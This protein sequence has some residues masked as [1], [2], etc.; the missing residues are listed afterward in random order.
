MTIAPLFEGFKFYFQSVK[1]Y[2][3]QTAPIFILLGLLSASSDILLNSEI[4]FT[5][6]ILIFIFTN[7]FFGEYKRTKN[8]T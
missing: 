7:V 1:K 4:L 3:S 8:R 5:W 2:S 6:G